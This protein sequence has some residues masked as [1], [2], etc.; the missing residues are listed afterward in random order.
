[1]G[2]LPSLKHDYDEW[3]KTVKQH[4]A[5]IATT[6]RP[7]SDILPRNLDYEHAYTAYVNKCPHTDAGVCNGFGHCTA[8]NE[9]T[10]YCTCD[11]DSYLDNSDGNCYPT[12]PGNGNCNGNGHCSKGRCECNA[13][14][15]NFRYVGDA[16]D[17]PCGSQTFNA[18]AGTYWAWSNNNFIDGYQLRTPSVGQ[19]ACQTF[20]GI[21]KDEMHMTNHEEYKD[22]WS[23][24]DTY[25]CIDPNHKV[26]SNN[27]FGCCTL[28]DSFTCEFGNSDPACS[29]DKLPASATPTHQ[30]ATLS[31]Q[32]PQK[33]LNKNQ[34]GFLTWLNESKLK[35]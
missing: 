20:T 4:P 7:L 28:T 14:T 34:H 3:L 17:I 33:P 2:G 5:P 15:D 19:C 8:C 6:L 9:D 13:L 25:S 22:Y 11:G 16:C 27:L 30:T 10:A 26:C 1:M 35:D 18:N 31:A 12:C 24:G 21:N 29:S 32:R 23:S